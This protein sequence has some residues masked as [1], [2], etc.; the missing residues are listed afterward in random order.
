MS[1]DP[2]THYSQIASDYAEKNDE[3]SLTD[4]FRT[5][6]DTFLESVDGDRV[7]DIGSGH[8]RDTRYFAEQGYDTVGVDIASGMLSEASDSVLEQD[9]VYVQA[10]VRSLPFD[11][12]SFDAVWAPATLFLLPYD[13]MGDALDETYRVLRQEGTA[14]IGMKTG[15]GPDPRDDFGSTVMQYRVAPEEFADRVTD[16]G[17]SIEETVGSVNNNGHGFQNYFCRK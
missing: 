5:L 13:E 17:L 15:D 12:A 11:D 3:A 4:I 14:V 2:R 7:I 6:R 1:T 8:G 9:T 10:D 16:A